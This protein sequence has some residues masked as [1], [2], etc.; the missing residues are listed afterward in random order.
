MVNTHRVKVKMTHVQTNWQNGWSKLIQPVYVA[1]NPWYKDAEVTVSLLTITSNVAYSKQTGN[2]PVHKGVYLNEDGSVNLFKLGILLTQVRTHLTKQR[3]MVAK[4]ELTFIALT[5][6]TQL[7]VSH[8]Q[9]KFLHV[10]LVRLV[11]NKLDNL[12]QL[13]WLKTVDNT[14]TWTLWRTMFTKDHK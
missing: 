14:L 12:Q 1:T 13:W 5:L 10:L 7:T 4:L 3:W 11:T 8:W 9:L 6:V 2:S